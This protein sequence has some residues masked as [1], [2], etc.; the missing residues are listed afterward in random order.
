MRI[1]GAQELLSARWLVLLRR[2]LPALNS[3]NVVMISAAAVT[4]AL[5]IYP[6]AYLVLASFQ[7]ERWGEPTV[8]TLNNYV[9]LFTN[10]RL[11]DALKNTLFMS[12]GT[13]LLATFLG[14]SLAWITARTN[15][16]WRER[17]EPLNLVPFYL[18]P[19]V[20]A[21]SWMYLAS[22]NM[23]LINGFFVRKLGF[24]EPRSTSTPSGASSG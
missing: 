1:G 24:A 20:G 11:L 17:L 13:S 12:L 6:M 21:I 9:R 2:R 15:A 5:V 18:S 19:L 23:G 3:A 22:P 16:P 10:P 14:V 8:L 4:A 7:I